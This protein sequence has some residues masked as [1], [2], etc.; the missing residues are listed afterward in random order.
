MVFVAV[1][2]AMVFAGPSAAVAAVGDVRVGQTIAHNMAGAVEIGA[3]DP[4]YTAQDTTVSPD[5]AS[6]YVV[7]DGQ[8]EFHAASVS[9]FLRA[10]DGSLTFAGCI[11]DKP[12]CRFVTSDLLLYANHVVA[13]DSVVFV[14]A[15]FKILAFY[16]NTRGDL[17]YASCA[18]ARSFPGCTVYPQLGD[19]MY[20]L[21]VSPDA[22]DVYALGR[23][24]LSAGAV[25]QLRYDPRT[26]TLGYVGCIGDAYAGCVQTVATHIL[27]EPIALVMSSDGRSL[28]AG[29]WAAGAITHFR[30]DPSTGTLREAGCIGYVGGVSDGL[31][32]CTTIGVNSIDVG[33]MAL[34]RAGDSLY[35]TALEDVGH[36]RRDVNTGDLSY[37]GCIGHLAGCTVA[38]PNGSYGPLVTAPDGGSVYIDDQ[39]H[40]LLHYRRAANGDLSYAGCI[41]EADP[42]WCT[43]TGLHGALNTG[44]RGLAVS[45]D[46]RS[47]YA[48]NADGGA[49]THLIRQ[50]S[51]SS[52]PA[53]LP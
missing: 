15:D 27:G 5:G 22:R 51:D 32:G 8:R 24:G 33:W 4:L 35:V 17:T 48:V 18:A 21:G 38:G 1:V 19:D 11:G 41:G 42:A 10:P 36:L 47:V 43:Q 44:V 25:I 30:R 2:A 16:R 53:L 20:G 23:R 39:S 34:T 29:A 26:G 7:S 3:D 52:L 50:T 12:P 14:L 9:H 46:S 40:G 45:P 37:A 49:I 28:Y 6:V 31:S 13:R